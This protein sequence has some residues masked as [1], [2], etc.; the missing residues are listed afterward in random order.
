LPSGVPPNEVGC[1]N[2]RV[3]GASRH[4]FAAHPDADLVFV[5]PSIPFDL[6]GCGSGSFCTLRTEM[7]TPIGPHDRK[8]SREDSSQGRDEC[9]LHIGVDGYVR[10]TKDGTENHANEKPNREDH[11]PGPDGPGGRAHSAWQPRLLR[12]HLRLTYPRRD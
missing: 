5:L 9:P 12:T 10:R 2:H 8:G 4:L 11:K 3:D 6:C 7:T 1:R